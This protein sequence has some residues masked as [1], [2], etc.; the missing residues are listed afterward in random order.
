[1]K[2]ESFLVWDVMRK[3]ETFFFLSL[4]FSTEAEVGREWRCFNTSS[5]AKKFHSLHSQKQ[6]EKKKANFLFKLFH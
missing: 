6:F 2:L 3:S 5:K 1:M 4:M